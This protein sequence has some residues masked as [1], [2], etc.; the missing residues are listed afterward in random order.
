[1]KLMYADTQPLA[2]HQCQLATQQR[3]LVFDSR[4]P[5]WCSTPPIKLMML[6][7]GGYIKPRVHRVFPNRYGWCRQS[8]ARE[9]TS[10]DRAELGGSVTLCKDGAAATWAEIVPD[11]EAAIAYAGVNL[12]RALQPDLALLPTRRPLDN[13]SASPLASLAVTEINTSRLARCNRL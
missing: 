5:E 9:A 4:A 11:L 8:E 3:D 1:M 13:A 2:L 7:H 10:R 12:R 6:R